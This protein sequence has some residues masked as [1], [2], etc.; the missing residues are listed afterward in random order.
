MTNDR[1]T[2][3]D[4]SGLFPEAQ[5][6]GVDVSTLQRAD[7][8]ESE[9]TGIGRYANDKRLSYTPSAPTVLTKADIDCLFEGDYLARRIIEKQAKME[10]REGFNLS[11]LDDDL[12][13]G[14]KDELDR[15]GVM[16]AFE[17]ARVW[18]RAHGGAAIIVGVDDGLPMSEPIGPRIRKI[19]WLEVV[20]RWR[21]QVS[22]YND[23]EKDDHNYGKPWVYSFTP[24]GGDVKDVHASRVIRFPGLLCSEETR[25]R[26]QGWG[27][28]VL[29]PIFD[30]IRDFESSYSGAAL[31]A[32]E[33]GIAN[34]KMKGLAS[35]LLAGNE[36]SIRQ[37][38]E[39]MALASSVIRARVMD[40]E[41]EDF[42]RKGINI[43]GLPDLL[44]LFQATVAAAADMPITVLFGRSPAG[45][46]ATGESDLENWHSTIR[47][48][49]G[50]HVRPR[51][52]QLLTLIF[53]QREGP[54]KG[55]MPDTWRI[56][57]NPLST[58]KDSETVATR[59]QQATID[60]T[61]VNMGILSPEEVRN[62][63][64][65]SGEYSLDTDLDESLAP[66]VASAIEELT[67]EENPPEDN[68]NSDE[69][70]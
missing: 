27:L 23:D 49:Q 11:D 7:G 15:L 8:W 32:Q 2:N 12:V 14:V 19:R 35:Q 22:E 65:G 36:Q 20:D 46:N 62:S 55:N 66:D 50:K 69:T 58:P 52:E 6:Q 18:E 61:Y 47:E 28:P 64:F 13:S 16:E 68:E 37:R 48:S 33:I 67:L 29:Q 40:G 31:L 5:H 25:Q 59:A 44:T 63:R 38:L 9:L 53:Q 42:E 1:K 10:F 24:I 17:N 21:L 45:M 56:Q 60:Q 3:M 54:T 30:T 57:F 41:I 4:V 70:L 34:Y 43:A 51:L 39:I 26:N